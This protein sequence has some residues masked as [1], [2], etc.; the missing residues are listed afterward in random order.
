[1][2]TKQI[3]TAIIS[4]IIWLYAFSYYVIEILI[5][6]H[7]FTQLAWVDLPTHLVLMTIVLSSFFAIPL[8]VRKLVN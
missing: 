1:M 7:K 8:T 5:A 6:K 3:A 2:T 4:Y